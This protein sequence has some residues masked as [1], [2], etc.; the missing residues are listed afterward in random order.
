MDGLDDRSVSLSNYR[1]LPLQATLVYV[2]Q[3]KA[4]VANEDYNDQQPCEHNGC[5]TGGGS[6]TTRERCGGVD[7]RDFY[8]R[9]RYTNMP[10]MYFFI[11]GASNE[12]NK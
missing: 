12:V 6:I 3:S 2:K 9:P 5:T 8:P 10:F 7:K 1:F 4:L 11:Y